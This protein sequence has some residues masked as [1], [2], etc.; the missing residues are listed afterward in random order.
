MF[1]ASGI[2]MHACNVICGL[3][4][5]YNTFSRSLLKGTI[6][7]KKSLVYIKCIW[8]FSTFLYEP[9][10]ERDMNKNVYWSPCKVLVIL[11]RFW[12]NLN[13]LDRFSKKKYTNIKIPRK[14]VQFEPSCSMRTDGQTDKTKLMVAFRNFANA[15][16]R[17]KSIHRRRRVPAVLNAAFFRIISPHFIF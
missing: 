11:V 12:L 13:F 4:D 1:V 9:V 2:S 5:I 15:P 8:I 3:S 10:L 6:F 14:S 16:K 7:E 17:L